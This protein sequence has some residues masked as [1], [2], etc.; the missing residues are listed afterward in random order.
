MCPLWKGC[1]ALKGIT[2]HR[3]R[4]GCLRDWFIYFLFPFLWHLPN[5]S[6]VLS[7]AFRASLG[8]EPSPHFTGDSTEA[9]GG[10][11]PYCSAHSQLLLNVDPSLDIRPW[12]IV[13]TQM[14]LSL[15]SGQFLPLIAPWP[16]SA[17]MEM[18]TMTPFQ[19]E[20]DPVRHSRSHLHIW[21]DETVCHLLLPVIMINEGDVHV[22]GYHLHCLGE[23]PKDEEIKVIG[24]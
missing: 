8:G 9:W 13:P 3:L 7:T 23:E 21:T 15:S 4:K 5:A 6:C 2:T 16:P 20:K 18:P 22:R 14:L 17:P 11:M 19:H 1:S 10:G 24:K 12:F